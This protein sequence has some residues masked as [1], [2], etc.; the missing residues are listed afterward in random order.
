MKRYRV[1]KRSARSFQEFARARKIEMA[2]GFTY[3]EAQAYCARWN[4]ERTSAQIKR[5]TK[6]E[7]EET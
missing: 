7:F 3:E 4:E 1:F 5:G 2:R 6:A